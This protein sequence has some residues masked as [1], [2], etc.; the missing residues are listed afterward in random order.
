MSRGASRA[1]R[2]RREGRRGAIGNGPKRF[3]AAGAG[4]SAPGGGR[5]LQRGASRAAG[6]G[7][8]RLFFPPP[9]GR[10]GEPPP[11]R[12]RGRRAAASWV[13]RTK[14]PRRE[15][16][17]SSAAAP[18]CQLPKTAGGGEGRAFTPFFAARPPGGA[19]LQPSRGQLLP[20]SRLRN[21]LGR[22][23]GR[24]PRGGARGAG[25]WGA[26]GRAV[27]P[28]GTRGGAGL[29]RRGLGWARAAC[30]ERELRLKV[31]AADGCVCLPGG[32]GTQKVFE[33]PTSSSL[34]T[35]REL[36][37]MKE[38]ISALLNKDL[39]PQTSCVEKM[40]SVSRRLTGAAVLKHF[41][42]LYLFR[43]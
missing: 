3:S 28:R 12:A 14:G 27:L 15:R 30:G 11:G 2:L 34:D 41:G 40:C 33:D 25:G 43:M 13:A 36:N 5:A 24:E 23:P 35:W 20:R 19:R 10:W 1:R 38:S 42:V 17:G 37:L 8:S 9:P 31:D 4:R 22:L 16:A 32:F 39:F 18:G 29:A 6:G 21:L 7:R 26:I